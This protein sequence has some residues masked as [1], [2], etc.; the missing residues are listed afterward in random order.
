VVRPAIALMLLVC[1][2][3][4]PPSGTIDVAPPD[5]GSDGGGDSETADEADSEISTD[6][7]LDFEPWRFVAVSDSHGTDLGIN[8]EVFTEIVAEIVQQMPEVVIFMGDLVAGGGVD[9]FTAQLDNWRDTMQPVYDAGIA[10]YPIRGNHD[11]ASV[12][13][14]NTV[15]SGSYQLPENGPEGELG[16][17][18]AV[19]H[20]SALFL[21]LDAYVT[22]N[23]INQQWLDN[24]LAANLAPHVFAYTHPQAFPPVPTGALDGFE[25]ERDQLW[26]SLEQAGARALFCGHGHYVNHA[27]LDDGD[28]DPDD[29]VHQLDVGTAGAT[30]YVMEPTFSGDLGHWSVDQ[31][32]HESVHGYLTGDVDELSVTL[33]FWR[34]DEPGV[35]TPRHQWS[36]DLD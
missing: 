13:A 25:E 29:D 22:Y 14:W 16:L 27:R 7:Y 2:C 30:L 3:D 1:G 18:Y 8:A 21:G 12:D 33:T 32:F 28:D 17:T 11:L 34:R 15:F 26:E 20:R 5:G 6:S 10:V 35:Y 19:E 9:T 31:L 24:Q 23:R 36:Y 4:L